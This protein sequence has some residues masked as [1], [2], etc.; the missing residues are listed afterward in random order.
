MKTETK[1]KIINNLQR[2]NEYIDYYK[3][4]FTENIIDLQILYNL[5]AI[6]DAIEDAGNTHGSQASTNASISDTLALVSNLIEELDYDTPI[7]EEPDYTSGE[8]NPDLHKDNRIRLFCELFYLTKGGRV[9]FAKRDTLI[10]QS[11]HDLLG[12]LAY[13]EAEC[14]K[15]INVYLKTDQFIAEH[16]NSEAADELS[17][18]YS[19]EA[20]NTYSTLQTLAIEVRALLTTVFCEIA[21][22]NPINTKIGEVY[23]SYKIN[24]AAI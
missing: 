8:L 5:I 16:P 20:H 9:P 13:L 1:E 4:R 19:I 14:T 12:L 3:S 21:A 2:Y 22:L 23:T 11:N 18:H 15:A 6:Y 10:M 24:R 7:A 17:M